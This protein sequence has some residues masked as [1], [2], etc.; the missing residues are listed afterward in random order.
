MLNV[1][2]RFSD[3][4]EF[5]ATYATSWTIIALTIISSMN[6]TEINET[7]GNV[8]SGVDVIDVDVLGIEVIVGKDWHG[9]HE[10]SGDV[11]W[12]DDDLWGNWNSVVSNWSSEV[13]SC[14]FEVDGIESSW[15]C[16]WDLLVDTEWDWTEMASVDVGASGMESETFLIAR[17]DEEWLSSHLNAGAFSEVWGSSGDDI[18]VLGGSLITDIVIDDIHWGGHIY[19]FVF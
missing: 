14:G 10:W 1:S 7:N 19:F 18:L 9:L 13:M 16:L 17:S 8:S 6:I 5:S 3:H 11:M 4:K 2:F 12:H 15:R